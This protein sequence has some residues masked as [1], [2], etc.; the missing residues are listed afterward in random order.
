MIIPPFLKSGD[1]IGI[2]APARFIEQHKYQQ[3]I[4]I[5]ATQGYDV[6]RGKTTYLEHGPFAG[7]DAERALDLQQMMDDASVKA[8]FCLRGGY[9]TI[10]IIEKINFDGLKNNPKWIIGFSDITVLHNALH[11]LGFTTIHGQMPLNFYGRK[12]NPGL[13]KLFEALQGKKP[14]YNLQANINNRAGESRGMVIGG[15]VA[16]LGSLIGTPYDLNTEGKILFIEEVGEY[17]YRFDRLMHQLKLSG[18]LENLAGLMVGGI[19]DMT[20]NDP[21]F[22]Q[23]AQQIITD[24]VAEYNYPVCFGFPAG[25]VEENFPLVFGA[26]ATLEVTDSQ[27]TLIFSHGRA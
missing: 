9:G 18:K 4:E 10:R 7:T 22:P 1:K 23:S 16:I 25:H 2:T 8:I 24:L 19:S 13:D 21:P 12:E 11:N 17:L 3:V 27:S 6:V 14:T 20:D 26:E 5:I 15:N